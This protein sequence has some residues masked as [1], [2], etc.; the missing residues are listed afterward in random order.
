MKNPL[1]FVGIR[2]SAP[3]V[4]KKKKKEQSR[5][6]LDRDPKPLVHRTGGKGAVDLSIIPRKNAKENENG[7][8]DTSEIEPE[9]KKPQ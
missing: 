1:H 2:Q 9:V 8:N 3:T 7:Y 6:V 4:K 5:T